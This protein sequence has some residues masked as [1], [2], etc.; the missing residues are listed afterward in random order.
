MSCLCDGDLQVAG[1]E[2]KLLASQDQQM[3]LTKELS[4]IKSKYRTSLVDASY[5]VKASSVYSVK[6]F[7][8]CEAVS[9]LQL[10][11]FGVLNYVG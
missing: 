8:C 11:C 1:L 4:E 5:Q 2:N 3:Q 7:A 10:S 6:Q 9:L